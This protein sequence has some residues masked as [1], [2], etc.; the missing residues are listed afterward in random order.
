[1]AIADHVIEP[2]N[3]IILEGNLC[4]EGIVHIRIPNFIDIQHAFHIQ[5]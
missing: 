1:M 3:L 5:R 4:T 2:S